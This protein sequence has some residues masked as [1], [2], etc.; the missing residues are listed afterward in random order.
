MR[1]GQIN[2]FELDSKTKIFQYLPS[3][4]K[5]HLQMWLN[6]GSQLFC[7]HRLKEKG[8]IIH[9]TCME[10]LPASVLKMLLCNSQFEVILS[11]PD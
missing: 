2:S 5:M 10:S 9:R 6:A 4:S 3:S 7:A 1:H 8:F 11:L